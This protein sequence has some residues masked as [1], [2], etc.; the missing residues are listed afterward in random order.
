MFR[1][2]KNF[3][4]YYSDLL[5]KIKEEIL[6]QQDEYIIAT[7]TEDLVD[8][9]FA[10][11]ALSPVILDTTTEE[12]LKHEKSTKTIPAERREYGYRA[13][14]NLKV[15][16]EKLIVK[17]P[18]EPNDG[19]DAVS[20]LNTETISLSQS[21]QFNVVGN[22][23]VF[24]FEIK[25]YGINY[26]NDKIV[27][28]IHNERTRI[29][30]LIISKNSEVETQ[31]TKL[32]GGITQFIDQRKA[33]LDSDNERLDSLVKRIKIPLERKNQQIVNKIQVDTKP[34][35]K[36]IKPSQPDENYEL[37]RQKVLDI[38]KL[39]DNQCHQ[40]EKNPASFDQF[41]EP[42]LRDFILANLN[43][44][45]EGKATGETFNNKGKTD[46]YLQIDKGNILVGECKFYGGN[47]LYHETIDQILG[48]LIWRQNY[49][50]MINFSKKKGFSKVL[51]DAK[52]IISSHSSYKN[53]F[54][55]IDKAHFISNHVLPSD[56]YKTVEIHHLYYN[57][58]TT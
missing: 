8:Y 19:A 6:K 7:P 52:E 11:Y 30:N 13:E 39:I 51:Q 32:K 20:K 26:D 35:V 21:N 45:F 18:I 25:G 42:N 53:G 2:N 1:R 33:K 10:K 49:G 24:E 14:G 56:D 27:N 17:L 43:S 31:N 36:R 46:I 55:K 58:Y 12:S 4:E 9:Y 15:E 3:R 40:F 16:C 44:I 50:I 5:Q 23:I 38:I 47:K 57:L 54:N 22:S 34:F 28:I 37:D 41:H 48:Y 29:E